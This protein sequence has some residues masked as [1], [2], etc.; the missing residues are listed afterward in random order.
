[1]SFGEIAN[2]LEKND[3][4]FEEQYRQGAYDQTIESRNK[5]NNHQSIVSIR[6]IQEIEDKVPA[7]P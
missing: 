6:D 4:T 2:P 3:L 1:M 5:Q 7:S